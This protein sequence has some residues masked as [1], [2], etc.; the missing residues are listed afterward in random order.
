[1][2]SKNDKYNIICLSNQLWDFP[3]WTNKRHIMLR[4]AKKGQNVLFVDPPIN[5]GNV[6]FRQIKRGLWSLKRLLTQQKMDSGLRVYTPVNLLPFS[7]ITSKMHVNRIKKLAAK[8]FDPKLKTLLWVYHVEIPNLPE[9]INDLKYDFLIYD[10]VDNYEGF[11][12][13]DT[14]QKKEKIRTI[15]K[16][17]AQKANVVFATAP[18]LIEK[19][20]NYNNHVYFTPNVGDY[21]KFKDAKSLFSQIPEDLLKI[22]RPRVGFTGALDQYKFDLPLLKK[23]ATENPNCSFVLIGQ[24]ALKDKDSKLKDLQ[25]DNLKNIYFLGQRSYEVLQYYFAGFD[26]FIIPYVLNDYTVGG[27][28]PV[29]FHDS[30][31]AGLPTIVTNLPAYAPFRDVCYIAKDHNEFSADIKK[32]IQEDSPQKIKARQDIAKDN[33]WDGKV[34][35]LLSIIGESI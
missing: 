15:E 11:P 32:A 23:I 24:I 6:F 8:N 34:E 28:F 31:A 5:A 29:K 18:G 35:M 27:C 7:G 16:Y 26:A 17:L 21:E 2:A 9:Y 14:P 12:A 3:N 1:M 25:I 20:K 4:L 13:Y 19:L 22:P 33:N 10:C 30:L